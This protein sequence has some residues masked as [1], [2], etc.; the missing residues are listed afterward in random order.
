[1][2]S[3]EAHAFEALGLPAPGYAPYDLEEMREKVSEFLTP[4]A[5]GPPPCPLPPTKK[6]D[7]V[8]PARLISVSAAA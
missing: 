2:T 3:D 1:M 8:A 4:C 6:P 5:G 7:R